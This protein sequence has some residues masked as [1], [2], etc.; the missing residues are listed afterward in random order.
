MLFLLMRMMM[1]QW[2]YDINDRDGDDDDGVDEY[3]NMG[4]V[5]ASDGVVNV[6]TYI[7]EDCVHPLR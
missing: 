5:E 7:P 3:A 6:C 4:Y 1:L 2:W